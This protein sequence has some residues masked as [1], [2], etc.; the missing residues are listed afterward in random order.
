MCWY[1][2]LR[3]DSDRCLVMFGWLLRILLGFG[4]LV[5]NVGRMNLMGLLVLMKVV[6]CGN[7]ICLMWWILFVLLVFW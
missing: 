1:R 7:W 3:N 4:D 5:G 2:W 6:M